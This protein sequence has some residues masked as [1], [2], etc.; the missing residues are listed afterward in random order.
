MPTGQ[1]MT[2]AEAKHEIE[3]WLK[4]FLPKP[5][6]A[7]RHAIEDAIRDYQIAWIEEKAGGDQHYVVDHSDD[8]IPF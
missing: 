4:L 3:Q 7:N 5:T 8:D 6:H 2:T 1:A